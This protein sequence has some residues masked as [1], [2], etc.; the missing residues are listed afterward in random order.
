VDNN[1]LVEVEKAALFTNYLN[2]KA[3]LDAIPQ[4][5]HVTV[6]FSKTK[7]VDHSV[8]EN[9]EHFASDYAK[10]NG[11]VELIG[12]H[13]HKPLSSHKLAARKK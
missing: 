11:T 12:L 5:M 10:S 2:L 7:L 13:E 3:K 9:I 6:D 1:Y 4:E 8:M